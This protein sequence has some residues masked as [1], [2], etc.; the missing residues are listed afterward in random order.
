MWT[1]TPGSARPL[2]SRTTPRS[3]PAA[4]EDAWPA[5]ATAPARK[6]SA[7]APSVTNIGLLP[8]GGHA[9]RRRRAQPQQPRLPEQTRVADAHGQDGFHL[10]ARFTAA[11]ARV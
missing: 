7:R 9:P 4:E 3:V 5:S 8:V 6:K 11:P 1:V 2:S 10:P